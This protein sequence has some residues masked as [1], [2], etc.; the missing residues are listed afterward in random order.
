MSTSLRDGSDDVE[1]TGFENGIGYGNAHAHGV[2]KE[3]L[4]DQGKD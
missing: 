1:S 4:G 2:R 3:E